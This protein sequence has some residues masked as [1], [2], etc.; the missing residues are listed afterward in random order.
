MYMDKL[1]NLCQDNPKE[2]GSKK[3]EGKCTSNTNS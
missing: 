1:T 3:E 2:E